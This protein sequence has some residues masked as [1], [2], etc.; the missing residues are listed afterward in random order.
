MR[1]VF[2]EK[3]P[4]PVRVIAIG[5]ADPRQH[6][7]AEY[8]IEFCGGTH[9]SSTG[10]AGFF[11][12]VAEEAVAK[13]VRRITGMTGRAAVEYVQ[14]LE[15]QVAEVQQALGGSIADA[16]RRISALQDEVKTLKKKLASGAGAG[17][18]PIVAA[19]KLLES[20]PGAGP[21][22]ADRRRDP[23]RHAGAIAPGHR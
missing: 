7:G 8:S 5:T 13:G 9:L 11:K 1:A 23:R 18:D 12:I 17:V 6:A 19:G 10:Q 2:G 14:S 21:R 3:Y 22:E 20:R 16:A 4:D 15:A